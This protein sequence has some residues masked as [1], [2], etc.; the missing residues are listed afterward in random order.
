L[1]SHHPRNLQYVTRSWCRNSPTAQIT[2]GIILQ[3]TSSRC[4]PT[5]ICPS[6]V[7]PKL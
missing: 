2:D 4:W 3:A 7:L 1:R 5:V 6:L